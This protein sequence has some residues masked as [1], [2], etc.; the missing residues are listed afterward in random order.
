V[1]FDVLG[2]STP[3][4]KVL[5]TNDDVRR[6]L[7]ADARVALVA[8]QAF[9]LQEDT[10]WFRISVGAVGTRELAAGLERIRATLER[11]T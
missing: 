6:H 11:L 8:F 1:R 3:E 10:G 5:R 7:L 2:R 4:G 9:G